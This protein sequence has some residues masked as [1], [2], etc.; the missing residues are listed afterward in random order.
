MGSAA[1]L[2]EGENT[3]RQRCWEEGHHRYR[4]NS[5]EEDREQQADTGGDL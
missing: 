2:T 1:V 4:E 3:G 5:Q